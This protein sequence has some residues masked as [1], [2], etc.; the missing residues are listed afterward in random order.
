MTGNL[1]YIKWYG[2]AWRSDPR[3]RLCSAAA[4][5][6]WA[7][8]LSLMIEAEPYGH[9]AIDGA[10]ISEAQFAT[11]TSTPPKIARG[12]FAE[13]EQNGVWSRDE[14]GLI[15]S[16]RMIRDKAKLD[17]A[18]ETGRDGGNPDIRR[19]TVPK[20]QRHRPFKRSDAPQKTLRIFQK[21]DGKCHWCGI[22]LVFKGTG[23]EANQFHVD[24]VLAICDGGTNDEGNLVAACA[25]CN[26]KRARDKPA[27]VMVGTQSDT[28][29]APFS[30]HNLARATLDPRPKTIDEDGGG[31][32]A[33]DPVSAQ[34]RAVAGHFLAERDRLW[35]NEATLPAPTMTLETEAAGWLA[36]G[37]PPGLLSDCLTRQMAGAQAKGHGPPTSLKAYRRSLQT[38]VVNW[39]SANE[40]QPLDIP[41]FLRR[42]APSSPAAI[43]I[44]GIASARS[45]PR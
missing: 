10:A 1:P 33:R 32:S 8:C 27:A 38:D 13:L 39:K 44:A 29:H 28:N 24:H 6:V 26:H 21:S 30:D 12:A 3:L 17:Q 14:D 41:A 22:N 9:L 16:R 43:A 18:R 23:E 11:L 40:Q 5:G 34:A 15:F 36:E 20:D 19:G 25:V 37:A 2:S 35:P 42:Q 31:G 4:R 45:G 7:D